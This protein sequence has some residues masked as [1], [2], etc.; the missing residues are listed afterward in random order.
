MNSIIVNSQPFD[1]LQTVVVYQQGTVVA[2][3]KASIDDIPNLV[4]NLS[5]TYNCKNVNLVGNKNFLER[6]KAQIL[7]KFANKDLNIEIIERG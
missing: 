4:L 3:H 7:T 6:T 1:A 5:N 2:T